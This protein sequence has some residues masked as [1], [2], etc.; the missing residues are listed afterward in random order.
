MNFSDI[1]S[2]NQ[3]S[4]IYNLAKPQTAEDLIR[5]LAYES[6]AMFTQAHKERL[7]SL[8]RQNANYFVYICAEGIRFVSNLKTVNFAKSVGYALKRAAVVWIHDG[9]FRQVTFGNWKQ[10]YKRICP[11]EAQIVTNEPTAREIAERRESLRLERSFKEARSVDVYKKLGKRGYNQTFDELRKRR[12]IEAMD[13][14]RKSIIA[15][16]KLIL[17]I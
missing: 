16:A 1:L 3:R 14:E 8:I 2:D 5:G 12:I 6:G 4:S 13:A 9:A 10:V 7:E 11:K 17:A 15:E